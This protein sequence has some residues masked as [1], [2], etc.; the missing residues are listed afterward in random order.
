[1]TKR[2]ISAEVARTIDGSGRVFAIMS[3]KAVQQHAIENCF[4]A[5]GELN[6]RRQ[7]HQPVMEAKTAE[8]RADMYQAPEDNMEAAI[9]LGVSICMP[10]L[11][12]SGPG[13]R[14]CPGSKKQ[15]AK[16]RRFRF[17]VPRHLF[18][19]SMRNIGHSAPK[20]NTVCP[21]RN[22]GIRGRIED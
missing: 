3:Q 11:S 18:W 16:K 10:H 20:R 8:H 5:N 2:K 1:M 12:Q 6:I 13:A 19:S 17:Q 22:T 9:R 7:E 4:E 15:E 14:Y 21:A